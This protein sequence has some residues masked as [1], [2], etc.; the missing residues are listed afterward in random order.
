MHAYKMTPYLRLILLLP[1]EEGCS[2]T[3]A[4][5]MDEVSH[6]FAVNVRDFE[7][8]TVRC[9][10]CPFQIGITAVESPFRQTRKRNVIEH[11]HACLVSTDRAALKEAEARP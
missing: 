7:T 5:A 8:L 11:R 10:A 1:H 6:S 2:L 3:Q 9:L 4:L